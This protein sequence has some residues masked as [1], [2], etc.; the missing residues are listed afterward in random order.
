MVPPQSEIQY[1][2]PPLILFK[3]KFYQTKQDDNSKETYPN[4][5]TLL[6]YTAKTWAVADME[7]V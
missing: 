4:L 5:K 1:V 3:Q 7:T 2:L 6:P